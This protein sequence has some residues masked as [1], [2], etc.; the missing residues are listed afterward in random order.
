MKQN[1]SFIEKITQNARFRIKFLLW[2]SLVFNL[3][4]SLFLFFIAK[5]NHSRW[6]LVCSIYY[7]LLSITRFFVLKQTHEGKRNC[8]KIKTLRACGCFLFAIN[9]VVS[10]MIFLLIHSEINAKYHEITVITIA[11]YTFLSLTLAIIGSVKFAKENDYVFFSIKIIN[12]ISASVSL[13]T[14]TN[15]MLATFGEDNEPLRRIILPLL[16]GFVAFFI[17][18][19][20][21]L[22]IVKANF[23]L[24]VYK[25]E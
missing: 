2:L 19:V 17:I 18:T 23:D 25:H 20:A 7:G 10:A 12:L 14:L 5:Q 22:M 16:S 6:F 15:T 4:Y 13:V 9:V 3:A 24:R 8:Q 11:T 21:I 1:V